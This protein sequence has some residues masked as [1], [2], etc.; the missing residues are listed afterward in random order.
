MLI[1]LLLAISGLFAY[2]GISEHYD[3]ATFSP[4]GVLYRV[5]GK[6]MHLYCTGE[7]A[8]TVILDSGIG[9]A[10]L[11]W[12]LVQPEVAKIT[13]VCSYDRAGYGWSEP[14]LPPRT[15]D[16]LADELH[17]LLNSAGIMGPLVLVGHSFGGYNMQ[18]YAHRYPQEAVGMVLVDSAH[19]WQAELFDRA[20]TLILLWVRMGQASAHLG[21]ARLL[22]VPSGSVNNLP[23]SM[24]APA[25]AQGV[26]PQAYATLHDELES[27]MESGRQVGEVTS[28]GDMPLVV[29]MQGNRSNRPGV[30]DPMPARYMDAWRRLQGELAK[31]SSHGVLIE[32]DGVGH[33]IPQERPDMVVDAIADV[34]EQYRRRLA[35]AH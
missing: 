28:L 25:M 10:A 31:K 7:G 24:R 26:R 23:D 17:A 2:E 14:G 13:R 9:S 15:S 11:G 35:L 1:I 29:I 6:T 19:E 20:D 33:L 12:G 30:L 4:P 16:H 3:A 22:G 27:F 8:P 21:L 34:V 18:L 5:E 32:G